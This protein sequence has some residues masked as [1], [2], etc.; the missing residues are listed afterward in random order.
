MVVVKRPMSSYMIFASQKREQVRESLGP[1]AKQVTVTMELARLWKSMS[2]TEKQPFVDLA[3]EQK[4]QYLAHRN[5]TTTVSA[6]VGKSDVKKKKPTKRTQDSEEDNSES[7][8]KSSDDADSDEDDSDNK[9]RRKP[10]KPATQPEQQQQRDCGS[11]PTIA[12]K[13]GRVSGYMVF[14][15]ERLP[16]IM[17][18]FIDSP[19]NFGKCLQQIGGEWKMLS[20]AQKQSY[21][22]KAKER[23]NKL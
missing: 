2:E 5:E 9:N 6:P 16:Q 1:D 18:S 22:E 12:R 11:N 17:S 20:Q 10:V 19:A 13:P 14:S 23:N 3:E 7:A 21:E 15:Q 8:S 4:R